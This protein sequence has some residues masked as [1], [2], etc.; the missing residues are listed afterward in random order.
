MFVSPGDIISTKGQVLTGPG[1]YIDEEVPNG[2]VARASLKGYLREDEVGAGK[3]MYSVSGAPSNPTADTDASS[4]SSVFTV[5]DMALDLESYVLATV[6]KV[7]QNQVAVEII[8]V[9][10]T[11]LRL[12]A[13]GVVR[14]EDMQVSET[15][16]LVLNDC[17]RPGDVIRAK[18]LSL[19]DS[20]QYFL[21]TA[22]KCCGVVYARTTPTMHGTLLVPVSATEMVDESTGVK[23]KRL[24]AGALEPAE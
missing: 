22:D 21:G 4:A 2:S 16:L 5:G 9:G 17:F 14:R 1:V 23:E 3:Y 11:K 10:N 18:V 13:K 8:A 12:T 24:V 20:R 7:M 6:I 19:G 15:D